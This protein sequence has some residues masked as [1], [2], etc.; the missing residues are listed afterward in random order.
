[1]D[2]TAVWGSTHDVSLTL[3][4]S[5]ACFSPPRGIFSPAG[6]RLLLLHR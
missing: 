3:S 5:V 1:M 4:L 2:G 6:V